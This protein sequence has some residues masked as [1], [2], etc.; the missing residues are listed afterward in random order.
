MAE[1]CRRK[2]QLLVAFGSCSHTGG[3]PGLANLYSLESMLESS[4][5]DACSAPSTPRARWPQ[6]AYAS[7]PKGKLKLPSLGH[8]VKTLDQV[9]EVDYYLPGCPPPVKLIVD[10]VTAIVEGKLPPKGAVLAP[11]VACAATARG[12]TRSRRSPS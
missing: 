8:T 12:A 2:S 11:D 4:Y 10:A 5:G 3:I 7:D 9:I 6:A 1:L